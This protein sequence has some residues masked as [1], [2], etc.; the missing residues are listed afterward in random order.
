MCTSWVQADVMTAVST[1]HPRRPGMA[2]EPP[3]PDNGAGMN[4]PLM[5][6][7][8]PTCGRSKGPNTPKEY[9]TQEDMQ[10]GT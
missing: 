5:G 9:G 7:R 2:I 6:K 8:S 10:K 3:A 1:C 4:G